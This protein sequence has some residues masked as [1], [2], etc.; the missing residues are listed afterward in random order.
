MPTYRYQAA[1]A[2]GRE[3]KGVLEA[4]SP[5]GARALLRDRGLIALTVEATEDAANSSQTA[6]QK[7]G[8]GE[9]ALLTRQYSALLASGMTAERALDALIAQTDSDRLREIL[10]GVRAEVRAGQALAQAMSRYPRVFPDLYRALVRGGEEAGALPRVMNE[11][12][13]YLEGREEI[14]QKLTLAM[15]YPAVVSVVAALVIGG[16]MIY[17][18]PQVANVF[19]HSRQTLPLLTR[20]LL[21]FSHFLRDAWPWLL[22]IGALGFFGARYFYRLP[23]PRRIVQHWLLALPT[24]G[25]LFRLEAGA[26]LASTLS[27]LL[28]GG[29]PLLKALAATAD[30]AA[31]DI[32]R[33]NI[34]HATQR[35]R[36]GAPLARAL[37]TE[38]LFPPLLTHFIASGETGGDLPGLLQH[39]ARQLQNELENRLRWLGGLI[40]PAL[41]VAMGAIV[42][43]I[44][45]AVLMPIIEMN[46]LMH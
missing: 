11:L 30:S 1:H 25:R 38:R 4:D 26:R 45:L 8:T 14:R 5:R 6:R 35:V 24:V 33:E 7:L 23:Q 31:L 19:A 12:A 2:D 36:E 22:P 16:L 37:E 9:L 29:V 44:V 15:L 32:F 40:E 42:L 27:I 28:S 39:A 18:V 34:R 17:V 21:G 20:G 13:D 46:Q 43:T 3:E 10:T 41:I